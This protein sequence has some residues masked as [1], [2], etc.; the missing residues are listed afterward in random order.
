MKFLPDDGIYKE[1][2]NIK[3]LDI[4]GPVY[5]LRTKISKFG[6]ATSWRANLT[7]FCSIFNTDV[8]DKC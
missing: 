4:G 2:K 1:A 6:N 5:K 7:T 3:D 8:R